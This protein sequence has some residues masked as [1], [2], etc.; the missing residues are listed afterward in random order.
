MSYGEEKISNILK[1]NNIYFEREKSFADLKHGL[2]RF[3]FYLPN[4]N[5]IIEF[6][7]EQHWNF[8]KHFYKTRQDFMRAQEN[9]RRKNSYCLANS[10]K[11]YR[12]P[13]WELNNI[14]TLKDLFQTKF[15]VTTKWWNDFL[16]P[17][18]I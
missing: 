10:I 15:L 3:D 18:K 4:N 12:I 17:P 14:N 7:G 16:K 13:Y 1:E 2:F 11:L 8:V 9:D 5:I 6:D